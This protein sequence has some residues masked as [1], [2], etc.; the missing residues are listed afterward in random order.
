MNGLRTAW[1]RPRERW[2]IVAVGALLGGGDLAAAA[3]AG[4]P[5]LADALAV[6]LGV[7]LGP[8]A[9]WGLA[10]ASLVADLYAGSVGV[11]SL[12]RALSAGLFV[13]VGYSLA[14][15]L[16][17]RRRATV[18]TTVVRAVGLSGVAFVAAVASAATL[19][20]GLT[21]LDGPSFVALAP[22]LLADRVLPA[23]LAA[24]AAAVVLAATASEHEVVDHAVRVR[25][26]VAVGLLAGSWSLGG[27]LLDVL[28]RDAA[29]VP[30]AAAALVER[31]PGPLGP[32]VGVVTGPLADGFQAVGGIVALA[33]IAVLLRRD[34]SGSDP[35]RGR[36]LD[37]RGTGVSAD[38]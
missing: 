32:P 17:A 24:P 23:V 1:T 33:G 37:R 35:T 28:R 6:P 22:P 26:A 11:P 38:E 20:L 10:V 19:A 30:G 4:R 21:L 9:A 12:V 31:V 8:A 7:A 18:G 2:R 5:V 29:S 25:T 15:V 27:L 13:V 34:L 3:V 14:G 16:P 36:A